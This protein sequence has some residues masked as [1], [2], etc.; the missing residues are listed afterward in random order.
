MRLRLS[1]IGP[2]C[3]RVLAWL[4]P[5]RA[6]AWFFVLGFRGPFTPLRDW[7]FLFKVQSG[8]IPFKAAAWVY[9]CFLSIGLLLLL[10]RLSFIRVSVWE[11]SFL[12][13]GLFKVPGSV[14]DL[15]YIPAFFH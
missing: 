12:G 1:R 11:N 3:F 7:T 9:S 10:F 4:A 13:F 8:F 5:F 6:P 14:C 15:G 2:S